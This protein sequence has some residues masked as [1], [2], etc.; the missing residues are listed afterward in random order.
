MV[1]GGCSDTL[2]E[3]CLKI[4]RFNDSNFPLR[5]LGVTFTASRL[6]KAEC[7]EL[8]AKIQAKVR[9][10]S[11]RSLSF[12]GRARLINSVIF[13]MYTYWASIFLLPNEVLDKITQIS[14]NY[15]WSASEDHKRTPHISWNTTCLPESQGGLGMKDYVNWNKALIAKLL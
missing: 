4:T 15:L 10:W 5:Y 8:I 14:R 11:T 13:G 12:A 3:K 9:V 2:K 6:T 1:L 7:S